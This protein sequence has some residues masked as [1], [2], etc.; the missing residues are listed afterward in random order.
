MMAAFKNR[1]K[2]EQKEIYGI[3][4]TIMTHAPEH[5]QNWL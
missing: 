1:E 5:L 2:R 3:T 4:S